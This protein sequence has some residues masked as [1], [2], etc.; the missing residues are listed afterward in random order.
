[1]Q[2]TYVN[3][4][5]SNLQ[6]STVRYSN[7]DMMVNMDPDYNNSILKLRD[8]DLN[9]NSTVVNNSDDMLSLP[10]DAELIEQTY[11]T[12]STSRIKS[13]FLTDISIGKYR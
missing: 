4:T 1:M 12:T 13:V 3:F 11:V 10:A 8:E 7:D 9:L 5:Y 2:D 6:L